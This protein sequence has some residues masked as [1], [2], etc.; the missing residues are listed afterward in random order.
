MIPDPRTDQDYASLPA[1]RGERLR[2]RYIIRQLRSR[3]DDRSHMYGQAGA[4]SVLSNCI[5]PDVRAAC[6]LL[7]HRDK[8][9]VLVARPCYIVMVPFFNCARGKN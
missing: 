5:Q 3:S 9:N 7:S 4:R 1:T 8:G 2:L 6:S